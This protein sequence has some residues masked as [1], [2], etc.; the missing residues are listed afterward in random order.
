M[1]LLSWLVLAL[2]GYST[3][4]YVLSSGLSDIS[5][6][7]KI[8]SPVG[9]LLCAP[10][11][12]LYDN[13]KKVRDNDELS[14]S[15]FRE[16]AYKIELNVRKIL[17][18]ISYMLIVGVIINISTYLLLSVD[19]IRILFVIAVIFLFTCI[20]IF[21]NAIYNIKELEN[22]ENILF[23]RKNAKKRSAEILDR[24]KKK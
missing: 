11:W 4:K 5:T 13:L 1:K 22:Y 3:A 21:A 16:V 2:V 15:E 10:L 12:K 23:E 14:K 6:V 17:F 8:I 18:N 20:G 19:K 9:V 7:L 24:M